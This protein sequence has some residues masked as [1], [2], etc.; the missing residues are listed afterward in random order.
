MPV[1]SILERV[2]IEAV[3]LTGGASARMGTDKAE[4]LLDGVPLAKR[5]AQALLDKKISVTVLGK[6]PIDGCAF[7]PDQ[8]E[9]AGPLSALAGFTPANDIVFVA[10]CDLVRFDVQVVDLLLSK[11]GENEI[12]VPEVKDRKQPLCAL[13]RREA[14]NKIAPLLAQ[15]RRSVMAWLDILEQVVITERDFRAAGI[16][17]R[18]A[19]GANTLEE[20]DA[21]MK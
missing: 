8:Q 19:L 14:F 12:A 7:V 6:K 20:F 4:L 1:E 3:L 2:E 9:Y 11:L 16:D 5:I 15:G 21:L 13:Y 18:S 17:V 10:S